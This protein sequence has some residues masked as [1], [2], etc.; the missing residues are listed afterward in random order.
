MSKLS[1]LISK[2]GIQPAE[3]IRTN[4]AIWK[5]NFRGKKMNDEE[6]ISEMIKYPKI[7]ERPIVETTERALVCRPPELVL[8]LI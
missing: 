1:S 6:Y 8:D 4:E 2:I 3:L 5:E 7:M